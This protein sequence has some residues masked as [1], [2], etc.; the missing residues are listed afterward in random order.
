MTS[1]DPESVLSSGYAIGYAPD[2]G[3]F[4]VFGC[5]GASVV[6]LLVWLNSGHAGALVVAALAAS[7]AHY[8]FPLVERKKARLGAGEY[9]VFLEGLGIIPWHA[10]QQV[11]HSSYF[12]RT[13]EIDELHIVLSKALP[14]NLIA[15]WRSMPWFRLLMK[16]PWSMTR[17]N[18]VKVDLEPFDGKPEAIVAGIQRQQRMYSGRR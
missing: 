4:R 5:L 2:S 6:F 10:I 11:R 18:I 14:K 17:D 8:Y 16:L 13:M 3:N 7:A 9:G 15:D 12:V 1:E